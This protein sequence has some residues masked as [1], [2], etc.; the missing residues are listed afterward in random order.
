MKGEMIAVLYEL[1]WKLRH[2]VNCCRA[3]SIDVGSV[4]A[5]VVL[6]W[7]QLAATASRR[8]AAKRIVRSQLAAGARRACYGCCS[9][10]CR[11]PSVRPVQIGLTSVVIIFDVGRRRLTNRWRVLSCRCVELIHCVVPL[12]A[13]VIDIYTHFTTTAPQQL[14]PATAAN[15][16]VLSVKEHRRRTLGGAVDKRDS[17]TPSACWW[18]TDGWTARW[19]RA[20]RERLFLDNIVERLAATCEFYMYKVSNKFE[21][22][23]VYICSRANAYCHH[24][25]HPLHSVTLEYNG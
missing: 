24:A 19:S 11:S 13:L 25:R 15:S 4:V 21:Y 12:H 1:G 9:I 7:R 5:C 2:K 6:R 18:V 8:G 3:N 22:C 17:T 20:S 14:Q 16:V 23:N 10:V